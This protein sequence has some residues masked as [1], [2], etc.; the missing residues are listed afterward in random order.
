[1]FTGEE[2]KWQDWK[3]VLSAYCAVVDLQMGVIMDAIATGESTNLVNS[4]LTATERVMSAQ[5]YIFG[6]DHAWP[7]AHDGHQCGHV[8]GL[9]R[10][11]EAH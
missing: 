8:G 6:H 7:A 10:V 5:L 4:G 11:G 2:Q 3:T 9:P 1:M